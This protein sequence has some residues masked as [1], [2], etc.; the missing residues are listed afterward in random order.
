MAT[1][2]IMVEKELRQIQYKTNAL[3]FQNELCFKKTKALRVSSPKRDLSFILKL[4]VVLKHLSASTEDTGIPS[5][6]SYSFSKIG[7]LNWGFCSNV[8]NSFST[9]GRKDFAAVHCS[10][11]VTVFYQCYLWIAMQ[12]FDSKS[13]NDYD[14]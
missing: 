13:R 1:K 9:P 2:L 7:G 14:T 6:V 12:L 11:E 4:P 8:L 10:K 3:T 5:N